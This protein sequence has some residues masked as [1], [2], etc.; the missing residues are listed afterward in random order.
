MEIREITVSSGVNIMG[1]PFCHVTC[2][3]GDLEHKGQLTPDEVRAMALAWLTAA[4]AAEHDA[5]VFNELQEG[6]D[7]SIQVAGGFIAALRARRLR[8]DVPDPKADM[9]IKVTHDPL[10]GDVT[11]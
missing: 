4:E 2:V 1:K 8:A 3:A 11:S 9:G 7:L 10:P 6:L 5:A